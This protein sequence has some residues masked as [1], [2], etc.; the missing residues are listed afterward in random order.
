MRQLNENTKTRQVERK[1]K[2]L[3]EGDRVV[4]IGDIDYEQY[5]L[6]VTEK[7]EDVILMESAHLSLELSHED[8]DEAVAN[9]EKGKSEGFPKIWTEEMI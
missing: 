4:Y 8:F 7:T 2:N 9:T 1:S 6:K 3:E 5:P